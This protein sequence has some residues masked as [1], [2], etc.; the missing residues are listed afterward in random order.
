VLRRHGHTLARLDALETAQT[1]PELARGAQAP[2]F[3]LRDLS[4][5]SVSL[6]EFRAEGRP[7]L[8]VFGN[9]ECGPC[10]AL[11]PDIARW[12]HEY[13]RRVTVALVTQGD[14]EL[15]REHAEE[16]GLEL[17]LLQQDR[18]VAGLYGANG[19]PAAVLVG[20]DG[21]VDGTLRYGAEGAEALLAQALEHSREGQR[22]RPRRPILT[23]ATGIGAVAASS[24]LAAPADDEDNAIRELKR[25]LR[26]RNRPLT[27][28]AQ[29]LVSASKR[30]I[31]AHRSGSTKFELVAA[32][33]LMKKEIGRTK[34]ELEA[35]AVPDYRPGEK[36]ARI[37]KSRATSSLSYLDLVL[38]RF[39]K[40]A[41]TS[42]KATI[43]R[44]DADIV[45][46]AIEAEKS[47]RSASKL[48]GCPHKLEDC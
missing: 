3:T 13:E 25:I 44:L 38:D 23:V 30:R 21:L 15:N 6:A 27:V 32:I 10:T 34:D 46:F 2:E 40:A 14:A 37:A 1:G 43:E 12:Q 16:H 19:T 24:A 4:G 26:S 17:V 33:A 28:Q 42:D 9:A 22:P 45:R 7:I 29:R 11:L 41:Q 39:A 47:R 31:A 35:V 18:E 8:L 48:L 5:E 36:G 20:P